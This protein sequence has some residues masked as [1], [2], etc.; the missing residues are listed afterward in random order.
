MPNKGNTA[1][2]CVT[3]IL[4]SANAASNLGWL[5]SQSIF[6]NRSLTIFLMYICQDRENNSC[7]T[8]IA[9]PSLSYVH[10]T[11]AWAP[12]VKPIPFPSLS[13]RFFSVL[14]LNVWATSW[15]LAQTRSR[16]SF[17]KKGWW[18]PLRLLETLC[19]WEEQDTLCR[20]PHPPPWGHIHPQYLRCGQICLLLHGRAEW[21]HD[22]ETLKSSC[23]CPCKQVQIWLSPMLNM[24]VC[25]WLAVDSEVPPS[26]EVSSPEDHCP[27]S[28]KVMKAREV[29][30]GSAA[31]HQTL[32]CFL[33]QPLV[34]SS[35]EMGWS[36]AERYNVTGYQSVS[37]YHE[38]CGDK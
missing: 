33:N 13:A 28:G 37:W 23:K 29:C 16:V 9:I 36:R 30:V 19:F 8:L 2:F 25:V 15:S 32:T 22:L 17:R 5:K 6:P 31:F 12:Q 4:C 20:S 26:E 14:G 24:C 11:P 38:R 1:A 34:W 35:M 3:V 21:I 10:T 27:P 18:W 7:I